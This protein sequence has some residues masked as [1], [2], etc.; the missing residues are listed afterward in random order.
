[1]TVEGLWDL[2]NLREAKG[3]GDWMFDHFR[4]FVHG[5]VAEIGAG[6]G[7]FTE[8]ILAAPAVTHVVAIEP[9]PTLAD[10]LRA[11]EDPRMEVA[12]E[13]LP[14]SPTLKAHGATFDYVLCQNV[15]EHIP[16]DIMATRAMAAAVKPGGAMTI[17]VPAHPWLYGRL[18]AMYGHERR[19]T[20]E[21]LRV[22]L[23]QPGL[24]IL[25]IYRFNALGILGW[26]VKNRQ[27]DPTLDPRSLRAYE[28]LLKLYR[29]I[30]DRVRLPVG[31]SLI[32]HVRKAAD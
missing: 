7:M 9:E 13:E 28:Q 5:R 32:A 15:L 29:P 21:R 12:A 16:D 8:R 17:L 10:R 26:I 22:A 4:P 20:P 27:T 14:D 23:D 2:E 31:L 19:Y 11:I 30:E 3:L 24:E 6:I 25:R 18:D 1:V